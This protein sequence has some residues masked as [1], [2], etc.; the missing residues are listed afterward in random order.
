MRPEPSSLQAL[1]DDAL[2]RTPPGCCVWVALSGGLD[3]CLLLT[4]AADACR[5]HPRPLRA[6]HVHH[7]L[8]VAADAFERHCRWLAS[9]LGVPLDV[10]HVSVDPAAGRGL[11]GEARAAR[12]AAFARRVREGETLWLAQHRDDQAETFLL[13][14]LRGAGPRGLAAMPE[15]RRLEPGRDG[16]RLS[17]PLLGVS[18]ST[19]EVEAGRRGLA[20]VE[21]PSNAEEGPD[22]NFLRHRVLPLLAGRWPRAGEGLARSAALAGEAE[23]LLE[24]LAAEDLARLGGDPG[25][26]PVADLLALSAP[27]RRLL[28]RHCLERLGLPR[29]P[30][31]RL[32]ALL[33][34]LA[35][36]RDA[37]VRVA[38]PGAEA[39][40]W[41][42]RLHLMAPPCPLAPAWRA[43]WDGQA[44]LA[45][46]L[47]R[48][49]VRLVSR[50]GGPVSLRLTPRRGGERLRLAGRGRRD[51]KR[52]LQEW[53]VPPWERDRLLVA[54][55]GDRVVA[56]GRPDGW[57]ACAE[58]WEA[59]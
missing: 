41:R 36:S 7:G 21:D 2:A 54:W 32:A 10:V 3:S 4:L 26:L 53:G 1:I 28:V 34:Q 18:R 50:A 49:G 16:A 29:P 13:A 25:R 6:L 48:L 56:V 23:G 57:L 33:D 17:R 55:H 9:R 35:A 12:Y 30:A 52:L 24:E 51:L 8:Q 45:T 31:R 42:A 58:G 39:R 37:A 47:G 38:W 27:R 40:V 22:R 43:D 44:P 15:A 20:W 5:R 11:E 14:A 19:L 46:P 59:P